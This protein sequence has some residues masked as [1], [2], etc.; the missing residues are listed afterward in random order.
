MTNHKEVLQDQVNALLTLEKQLLQTVEGQ[1]QHEEIVNHY[2]TGPLV[3]RIYSTVKGHIAALEAHSASLGG[4]DSLKQMS[5][6]MMGEIANVF[7]S[8][9]NYQAAKAL[10]DDYTA[11]SLA[12][13]SYTMLHTTAVALGATE[14]ADLA[15]R[16]LKNI[17]PIITDISHMIPHAVVKVLTDEDK[18]I[19]VSN[20]G[21]I[22]EACTQEAWSPERVS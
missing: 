4:A 14:T 12:A 16:H 1:T 2:A 22:S 11:L 17:T 5:A 7:A 8:L 18:F 6:A 19:V 20:A 10:R 15:L 13:I 21:E 9:R 3:Q